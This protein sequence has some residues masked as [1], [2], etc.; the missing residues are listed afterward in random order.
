MAGVVQ[1]SARGFFCFAQ[2]GGTTVAIKPGTEALRIAF[3]VALFGLSVSAQSAPASISTIAAPNGNRSFFDAS[4]NTY[5]LA[6]P[7]TPGSAQRQPGGGTCSGTTNKGIPITLPCPDAAVSKVDPSG[8][9]VWGTLLGG[10]MADTATALAVDTDGNVLLRACPIFPVFPG[11][12]AS[13]G[14]NCAFTTS[15]KCDSERE[16]TLFAY[17]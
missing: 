4:G 2:E 14:S 3:M 17:H 6:G 16:R 11:V 9:Q 10:P 12:N 1:V 7:A 15:Y 5:Y 13:E 8:N